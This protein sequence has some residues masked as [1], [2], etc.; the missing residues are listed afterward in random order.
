MSRKAVSLV[1]G[2]GKYQPND[3]MW[4]VGCIDAYGAISARIVK[5][6]DCV[7]H[8]PEESRGKRWRWNIWGQEFVAARNPAHER[9]SPE[10]VD[11]VMNW[12]T[13]KGCVEE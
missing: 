12:L 2:L 13:R 10:E 7:T 4:V 3:P 9:L 1:K 6:G 8:T 5:Q 11:L